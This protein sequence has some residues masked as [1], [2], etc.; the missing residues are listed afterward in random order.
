LPSFCVFVRPRFEASAPAHSF[1]LAAE[2]NGRDAKG[3]EA[4]DRSQ[5]KE[6]GAIHEY[7]EWN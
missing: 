2:A 4:A 5:K 3:M 6:K 1:S 7:A